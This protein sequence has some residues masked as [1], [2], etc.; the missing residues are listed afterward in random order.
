MT[1]PALR[2]A[3]KSLLTRAGVENPDGDAAEILCA[4]LNCSR[5]ELILRDDELSDVESEKAVAMARRRAA[6]EP[7]QYV[8]GY[9]FFMDR[10]YTVGEGVLIPRD[11]TEVVVR[12]ALAIVKAIPRPVIV[13]LCSGSGIIAITLEKELEHATVYA[14]EKSELAFSYL[15]ENIELHQ[16]DVEAICA[17]LADCAGDFA[18]GSLDMIISNPPYIRSDEIATLQREVQY[19]PRLALDG[20]ENG[21]DFYEMIISLWTKKLKEG[22]TIAFEIGEG[23]FSYIAELLKAAGYTDIKGTK[24]IQGTVRAITAQKG[25]LS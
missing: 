8:L 12:E 11:D 6:G 2:N 13:D 24:D 1:V 16:A 21:Y 7:I 3:I 5:T 10:K 22:G 17:D 14:V 23:Q 9:W 19:E 20:G 25:S 18:D 4:A 15:R